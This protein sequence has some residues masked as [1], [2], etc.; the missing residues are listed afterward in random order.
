MKW[1]ITVAL[2]GWCLITG[3][4]VR[5][6]TI[7]NQP[8]HYRSQLAKFQFESKLSANIIFLGNSIIEG[9]NWR[10]MLKDSSV[11]RKSVV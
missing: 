9:G 1:G 11:D 7:P 10:A 3:A 6:D 5:H 2:M 4:Q 8:D